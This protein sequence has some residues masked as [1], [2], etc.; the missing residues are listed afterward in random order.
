MHSPETLA[1]FRRV[2]EQEISCSE[3]LGEALANEQKALTSRVPDD[4]LE[5][6][7][8]K[9][10]LM[11][12]LEQ[13][14]SA[15]QGFLAAR[16]LPPGRPGTEAFLRGLTPDAAERALWQR[17]QEVAAHCREHNQA[18][19]S[20]VALGRVRTQRALEILQGGH[21]PA[22][23]YGRGGGTNRGSAQRFLGAV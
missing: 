17:L 3:R 8:Q 23:T 11:Q 21:D 20:L 18:N 4:L 1:L 22:K 15:H 14:V 9:Q 6:V 5:A 13:S 2:V 19:G 10:A 16:R 12:A 7:A